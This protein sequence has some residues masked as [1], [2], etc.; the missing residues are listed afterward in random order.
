MITAFPQ[1]VLNWARRNRR[2]WR[3]Y[4]VRRPAHRLHLETCESRQLLSADSLA[5]NLEL[6]IDLVEIRRVPV[7][8]L[9][10]V[11]IAGVLAGGGGS[12]IQLHDSSTS[13]DSYYL[14]SSASLDNRAQALTNG[15]VEDLFDIGAIRRDEVPVVRISVPDV[16]PP[17]PLDLGSIES[18]ST[19]ME[20]VDITEIL[21]PGP[22][23]NER[24]L[25]GVPVENS[26]TRTILLQSLEG[27]ADQAAAV[28]TLMALPGDVLTGRSSLNRF[29]LEPTATE[30]SY[31]QAQPFSLA[32][33][34]RTRATNPSRS[35][36]SSFP[37]VPESPR[38]ENSRPLADPF[39][40]EVTTKDDESA[41]SHDAK[42][43]STPS[44]VVSPTLSGLPTAPVSEDKDVRQ[45]TS[46]KQPMRSAEVGRFVVDHRSATIGLGVAASLLGPAWVRLAGKRVDEELDAQQA[47]LRRLG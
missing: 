6:D 32:Q 33:V 41:E 12:L 36:G 24:V 21:A 3:T 10:A 23:D 38:A 16:S 28:D 25:D 37:A 9:T 46:D 14:T 29:E 40:S 42:L 15:L 7:V 35:T 30:V 17:K 43:Q 11:D 18:G 45:A 1:A 39:S 47:T 26:E 31:G 5:L 19:D 8:R 2:H 13:F 20:G 22:L 44:A 27:F 4:H 34:E